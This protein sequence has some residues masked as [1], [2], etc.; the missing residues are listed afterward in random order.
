MLFA[1]I[2]FSEGIKLFRSFAQKSITITV[3]IG[4]FLVVQMFVT[5][6]CMCIFNLPSSQDYKGM[7]LHSLCPLESD[8]G[9]SVT[10]HTEFN[11]ACKIVI[12]TVV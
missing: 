9:Q 12:C 1:P 5:V 10:V 2:I 6:A 3:V 7:L 4:L 11:W 8:E